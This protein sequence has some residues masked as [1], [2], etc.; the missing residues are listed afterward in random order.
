MNFPFFHQVIVAGGLEPELRHSKK[1]GLDTEKGSGGDE[2]VTVW[3]NT[4]KKKKKKIHH[5]NNFFT[6]SQNKSHGD[7][8]RK[9]YGK[10]TYVEFETSLDSHKLCNF[11]NFAVKK[12][13]F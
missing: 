4:V 10:N 9:I 13:I 6:F 12:Q 8:T 1:A 2:M 5:V 11:L 3:G 7:A